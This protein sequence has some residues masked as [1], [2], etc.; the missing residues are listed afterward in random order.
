MTMTSARAFRFLLALLVAFCLPFA[1]VTD[2]DACGAC[3][4]DKVAAV[5][6]HVM[7]TNAVKAG[8]AVEFAEIKGTFAPDAV[9]DIRKMI[10]TVPG[11]DADPVKVSATPAVV[12]FVFDPKQGPSADVLKRVNA[13]LASR[14]WTLNHLKVMGSS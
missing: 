5:Y 6:D 7:V 9:A 11:V 10:G 2:A 13:K 8:K 3:H 4:E 12:A 1:N 14:K